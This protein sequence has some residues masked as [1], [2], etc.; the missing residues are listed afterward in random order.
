MLEVL[1]RH[2]QHIT[3]VCQEYVAAFFTSTPY[4][5]VRVPSDTWRYTRSP[6]DIG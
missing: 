3:G 5:G 4:T 6:I 1:L 2:R